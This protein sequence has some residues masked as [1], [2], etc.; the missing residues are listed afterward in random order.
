MKT[1]FVGEAF[2]C[3]A[4]PGKT[5][6]QRDAYAAWNEARMARADVLTATAKRTTNRE[7]AVDAISRAK[8]LLRDVEASQ[9]VIRAMGDGGQQRRSCAMA[10]T[11]VQ[12]VRAASTGTAA[13]TLSGYASVFWKASDPGTQYELP[14]GLMERIDPHA[15]DS[16]LR[17]NQEVKGLFNH[18]PNM[19]LGSRQNGTVRLEVDAIGLRYHINVNTNTTVGADVLAMTTRGDLTG[20]SFAFKPVKQALV[21]SVAGYDVRL[22][23]D[24]ILYDICPVTYPAYKSAT[25]GARGTSGN[26]TADA[27]HAKR[28]RTLQLAKN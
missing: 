25:V 13:T 5:L 11:A 17:G 21:R 12:S 16:T 20:S 3:E 19:L 6:N 26:R 27:A 15:Y 8:A 22:I 28:L 9:A 2:Y 1:Y 4:E 23:S 14:S 24:L 7:V 10:P 18:D